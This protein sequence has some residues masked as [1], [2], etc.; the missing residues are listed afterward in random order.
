MPNQLAEVRRVK[1]KI[2]E[3]LAK[4]ENEGNRVQLLRD[5]LIN[6]V[7]TYDERL[8]VQ[9]LVEANNADALKNKLFARF[10]AVIEAPKA[11]DPDALAAIKESDLEGKSD[12]E[13]AQLLEARRAKIYESR[14]APLDVGEREVKLAH[15]LVH[16]SQDA[17]WQKRAMVVT[18]LRRYVKAVAAQ[19]PRFYD[20]A[21]RVAEDIRADQRGF[22]AQV[23]LLADHARDATDIANRQ[24][25]PQER[26]G[27]R[28]QSRKRTS[29]RSERPT[30]PTSRTS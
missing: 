21:Q 13:K 15:L 24:V 5:W 19:A 29:S 10:D 14:I 7:E 25:Q 18:G 27:S 3:N 30:S 8:E 26:N 28:R 23:A 2:E 6:Q 16:L 4:P 9:A 20:M 17:A 12:E 22:F 1:A 11:A